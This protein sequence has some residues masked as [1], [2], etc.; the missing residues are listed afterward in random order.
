MVYEV[1]PYRPWHEVRREVLYTSLVLCLL[2]FAVSRWVLWPVKISGESMVP[3]YQDGQPNFIN[4]LAYLSTQPQRGDVVA[5]RAGKDFLIKRVIGLPGEKIEF[6]RGTI[7]VNGQPLEEHYPVKPLLWRLAPVELGANDYFVMGD[8]RT[9]S[10]LGA[11]PREKI[12][13]KAIF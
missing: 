10:L 8:N 5:L 6:Y 2:S 13:G 4:R 1:A 3:N 9:V 12:I 11:V 7:I